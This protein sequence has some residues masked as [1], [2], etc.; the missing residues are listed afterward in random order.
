[1]IYI[2]IYECVCVY[3]DSEI[4]CSYRSPM[5]YAKV[6]WPTIRKSYAVWIRLGTL[7]VVPESAAIFKINNQ[8]W[9]VIVGEGF[10]SSYFSLFLSLFNFKA[11]GR[12]PHIDFKTIGVTRHN[13]TL[14]TACGPSDFGMTI[15][16]MFRTCYGFIGARWIPTYMDFVDVGVNLVFIIFNLY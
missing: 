10:S 11:I 13:Q 12:S 7:Q 2:Y 1:M 16:F 9:T 5:V 15:L 6:R 8:K 3:N 4:R 14:A